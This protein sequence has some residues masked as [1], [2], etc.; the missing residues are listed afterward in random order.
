MLTC[1]GFCHYVA[2]A[3]CYPKGVS[4]R[5][6]AHHFLISGPIHIRQ[7]RLRVQTVAASCRGGFIISRPVIAIESQVS[8]GSMML[9][10]CCCSIFRGSV[11]NW[12]LQKQVHACL[13]P[14]G[15]RRCDTAAH[16][17]QVIKLPA[18]CFQATWFFSL[19]QTDLRSLESAELG[20]ACLLLIV[21]VCLCL[22]ACSIPGIGRQH[23]MKLLALA[24]RTLMHASTWS[25]SLYRY[26]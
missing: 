21:D 16:Q 24:T 11:F 17:L 7:G 8:R 15:W 14:A 12:D 9:R 25:G 3:C 1:C 13:Q 10:L 6:D 5:A 22:F 4:R 2:G 23:A 19:C 26:S 20:H 18:L